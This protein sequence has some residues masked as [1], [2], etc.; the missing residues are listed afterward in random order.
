MKHSMKRMRQTAAALLLAATATAS[1]GCNTM[2][3]LLPGRRAAMAHTTVD[4]V[5]TREV[6]RQQRQLAWVAV[7]DGKQPAGYT[8]ADALALSEAE[9]MLDGD[10]VWASRPAPGRATFADL[11]RSYWWYLF[12]DP[13]MWSQGPLAVDRAQLPGFYAAMMN[14]F[15]RTL[16][17]AA[18]P[19]PSANLTASLA[20][21]PAAMMAKAILADDYVAMHQLVTLGVFDKRGA[22]TQGFVSA[23][24]TFTIA[25]LHDPDVTHRE[26]L[27]ASLAEMRAEGLAA[28]NADLQKE[29]SK[30]PVSPWLSSVLEG[31]ADINPHSKPTHLLFERERDAKG[32]AMF[33]QWL[34]ASNSFA[35]GEARNWVSQWL[36]AYDAEQ[37][38]ASALSSAAY[39]DALA[40][41]G[42]PG[43]AMLAMVR[44]ACRLVR[45]LQVSHVFAAGGDRLDTRLLLNKLLLSNGMPPTVIR[46]PSLFAGRAP[47]DVLAREVIAGQ[48]RFQDLVA[49]LAAREAAPAVVTRM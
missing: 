11:P 22:E 5:R 46:D 8:A 33:A 3:R 38:A 35:P 6:L 30:D 45:R 43:E 20:G 12:V 25:P 49:E 13:A 27:S 44:P 40:A 48:R 26:Q 42:E 15:E 14:A 18:P 32:N 39:L 16:V 36:A 2:S 19:S 23:P 37:R 17:D 1:G 21:A 47:V 34:R 4:P 29:R 24:T 41:P 31:V 9:Q 7:R 10:T 28:W